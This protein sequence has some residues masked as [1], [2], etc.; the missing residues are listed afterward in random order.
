MNDKIIEQKVLMVGVGFNFIMALA[1]WFVYYLTN[2]EVLFLDGNFSFVEALT[3]IGAFFISK[4]SQKKTNVFPDGE[5]VYE[6]LYAILKG[7]LTLGVIFPTLFSNI[8]RII[9][10]FTTGK[11][12][13]ITTYAVL[14]Y[15]IAMCVHLFWI[16]LLLY[17][18]EEK[19]RKHKHHVRI[20]SHEYFY[21][22]DAFSSRRCKY[23]CYIVD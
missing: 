21:R 22:R 13:T 20:R 10:Y 15:T 23:S 12:Y 6:P 11:G 16:I 5:F 8:L 1:G 2:L 17:E 9:R 3:C 18:T 14:P 7:L 19:D 4:N